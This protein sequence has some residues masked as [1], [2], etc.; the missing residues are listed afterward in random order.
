MI[1]R[2]AF[3]PEWVPS[4]PLEFKRWL[5]RVGFLSFTKTGGALRGTRIVH[6]GI[7]REPD[8]FMNARK[9]VVSPIFRAALQMKDRKASAAAEQEEDDDI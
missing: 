6:S 1:T 8:E 7:E 4:D 9:V 3:A 5:Y 2:P